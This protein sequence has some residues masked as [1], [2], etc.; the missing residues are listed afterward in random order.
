MSKFEHD[1]PLIPGDVN[2]LLYTIARVGPGRWAR[3][4]LGILWTDDKRSLQV[5]YDRGADS[6]EVADFQKILN[7]Y[8]IA[9]LSATDA[10]DI[11]VEEEGNP[12]VVS[13]DLSQLT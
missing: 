2:A 5:R 3:I 13:G 8:A 9:G 4:P 12:E 10:F 7:E 6:F 1:T 11:T